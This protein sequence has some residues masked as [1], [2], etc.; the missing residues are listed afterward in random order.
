M[1]QLRVMRQLGSINFFILHQFL[2]VGL[3]NTTHIS[4]TIFPS[5]VSSM[6]GLPSLNLGILLYQPISNLISTLLRVRTATI[7]IL[8]FI[9]TLSLNN[10]ERYHRDHVTILQHP[11]SPLVSFSRSNYEGGLK[12]LWVLRNLP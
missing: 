12:I 1:G 6:S 2:D 7:A 8:T 5:S 11:P 3:L 4:L 9:T 10:L